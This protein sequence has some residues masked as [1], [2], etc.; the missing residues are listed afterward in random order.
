MRPL[1]PSRHAA[2]GDLLRAAGWQAR[3]PLDPGAVCG[4]AAPLALGCRW[5]RGTRGDDGW[6]ICETRCD[7]GAVTPHGD[8]EDSTILRSTAREALWRAWRR[9]RGL[10]PGMSRSSSAT[11]R[12][13]RRWR[14]AWSVPGVRWRDGV[15]AQRRPYQSGE[16]GRPMAEERAGTRPR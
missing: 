2:W 5:T 7:H 13:T 9:W 6:R 14:R 1:C 3:P 15:G 11:R 8:G 16:D 4:M 12:S 10:A